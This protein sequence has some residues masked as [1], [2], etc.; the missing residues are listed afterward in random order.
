MRTMLTAS[1]Q[2]RLLDNSS[3]DNATH[4]MNYTTSSPG[5]TTG[6]VSLILFVSLEQSRSMNNAAKFR[7]L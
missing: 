3:K 6:G 5:A 2:F 7:I 1:Y 4:H